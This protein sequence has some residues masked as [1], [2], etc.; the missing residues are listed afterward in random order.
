MLWEAYGACAFESR[1]PV[2]VD[3]GTSGPPRRAGAHV[4]YIMHTRA[5]AALRAAASQAMS[6]NAEYLINDGQLV[7]AHVVKCRFGQL[8]PWRGSETP[9]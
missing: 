8:P 2:A 7:R 1:L 6:C 4:S 9:R 3:K 5:A